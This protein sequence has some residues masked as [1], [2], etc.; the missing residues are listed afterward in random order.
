MS[1]CCLDAPI[2]AIL[3]KPDGEQVSVTIPAGYVLHTTSQT[4][5]SLGLVDVYWEG[6]HYWIS[7]RDLLKN[8]ELVESA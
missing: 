7:L 4:S 1:Q 6:R 2:Q 3:D 5:T 8:A